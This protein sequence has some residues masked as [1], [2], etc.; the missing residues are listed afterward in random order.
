[1]EG[2]ARERT[3]GARVKRSEVT[4]E[5]RQVTKKGEGEKVKERRGKAGRT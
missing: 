2:E 1:M 4:L 5:W 3:V